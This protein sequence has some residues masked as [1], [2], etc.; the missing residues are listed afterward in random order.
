MPQALVCKN[1]MEPFVFTGADIEMV[2]ESRIGC[3]H[4]CG[5]VNELEYVRSDSAGKAVYR[6]VAVA[7][8]PARPSAMIANGGSP[9]CLA[10]T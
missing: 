6:I 1:C 2:G 9:F 4:R 5:A 8:S 7:R 10:V 3:R